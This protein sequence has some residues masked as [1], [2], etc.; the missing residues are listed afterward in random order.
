VRDVADALEVVAGTR[1]GELLGEASRRG[2]EGAQD[3]LEKPVLPVRVELPQALQR[4]LVELD[5]RA[6]ALRPGANG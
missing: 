5:G 6:H 2:V 4:L 1:V 3:A